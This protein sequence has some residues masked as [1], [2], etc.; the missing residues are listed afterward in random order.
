MGQEMQISWLWG[1]LL[2]INHRLYR[3]VPICIVHYA[4][5]W[6]QIEKSCAYDFAGSYWYRTIGQLEEHQIIICMARFLF[7]AQNLV[8]HQGLKHFGTIAK[9][10]KHAANGNTKCELCFSAAVKK[11]VQIITITLTSFAGSKRHVPPWYKPHNNR[12]AHRHC[13]TFRRPYEW[14]I[15]HCHWLEIQP[16]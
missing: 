8:R 14:S 16:R 1:G 2:S 4:W 13:S 6:I 15:R 12:W 3:L 10:S 7:S 11:S 5:H 9:S